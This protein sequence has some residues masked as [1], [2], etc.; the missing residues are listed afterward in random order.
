M[1]YVTLGKSG[2][3]SSVI[4]L[5]GGS[6]GRFGLTKG[7]S[8]AD[9]IRLI[10]SALDLGITL[11]DGAGICG[12]V[13]ELLAE[14]LG[15]YRADVLLCTKFHLGPDV[16]SGAKFTNRASH[17]SARRFG[18][19]CTASTIRRR[20]EQTLKALRTDRIDLLH[21]HAV[22]PRQYPLA[23]DRVLPELARL[24]SEGKLRAIGV[25]EGF[26]SDPRHQML[27]L[28]V[29]DAR[30]DAVMS[31]FNFANPSAADQVIPWAQSAGIGVIGMFALRGLLGSSS[32]VRRLAEEAGAASL[33][34]LAYRYARHQPGMD[35]V[36]TGTGDPEHLKQNV[37]AALAPP[38]PQAVLDRLKALASA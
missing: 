22:T 13:D 30:V 34:D 15:K 37:A 17:W 18:W 10:R 26:V 14:G 29:E 4:G 36:L 21:L 25:T 24:K 35:A 23:A 19:V 27:R 11:F 1:D 28:A 2:L 3:V 9:A 31:G 8:K 33:S 38:L 16:Y 7:G 5:G 6:S 32:E 20:V 12:G